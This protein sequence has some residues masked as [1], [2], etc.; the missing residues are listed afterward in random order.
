MV[1]EQDIPLNLAAI[2]QRTRDHHTSYY[3]AGNFSEAT[4]V[5]SVYQMSGIDQLYQLGK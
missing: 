4:N 5:P 3:F 1:V 2:T